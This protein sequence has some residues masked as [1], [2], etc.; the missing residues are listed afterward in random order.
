[1]KNP[2]PIKRVTLNR[3]QKLYVIPCGKGFSCY[4]FK[5]CIE[6]RDALAKELDLKINFGKIGTM[7]AYHELEMLRDVARTKHQET[8]WR[9]KTGLTPQLIGLEGKRVEVETADGER[10]RFIVGKSTGWIPCHLEIMRSNSSGGG[11]VY[12]APFKSVRVL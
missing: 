1:M 2:T 11:S 10:K 12:G 3:K 8:G 9:S 4:G 5:N 6:E 7:L